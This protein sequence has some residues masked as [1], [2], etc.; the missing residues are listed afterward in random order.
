[1]MNAR[2]DFLR[3]KS[4]GDVKVGRYLVVS[5][6]VDTDLE[7]NKYAFITSKKVG[8][9]HERNFVRRRIRSLVSKHGEAFLDKRYLVHIGRYSAK[10][11]D[12]AEFEKDWLKSLKKLGVL[13]A[14]YS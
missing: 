12:F 5:T 10:D 14:D 1:M 7:S 13:P 9:A 2:R 3:V 11:S 8:K 4:F 6:L